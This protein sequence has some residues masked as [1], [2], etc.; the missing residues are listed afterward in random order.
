M[1]RR[2]HRRGARAMG[3]A[4]DRLTE[5]VAWKDLFDFADLPTTAGSRALATA[6]AASEDASVVARLRDAGMVCIGRVNMTEFAYSGIGLNPHFSVRRAILTDWMHLAFPVVRR[7]AR[8]SPSR[9]D[10]CPSRP[11]P[12]PEGP[13]AFPLP[14]TASLVTRPLAGATR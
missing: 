2:V 5:P 8:Q 10:S 3:E 9:A 14:S 12:T 6:P 1:P 13:L 7:Q 4:T 11:A